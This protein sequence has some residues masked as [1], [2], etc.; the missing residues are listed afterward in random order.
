MTF[1]IDFHTHP[2]HHQHYPDPAHE[3]AL[4]VSD[5]YAVGDMV[6]WGLARKLDGIAITDHNQF[7]SGLYGA[8]WAKENNLSIRVIPGAELSVNVRGG[9]EVHILALGVERAFTHDC[10]DSLE[11]VVKQI[12]DANGLAIMA[13]PHYYH[14]DV[15]SAVLRFVDGAEERNGVAAHCGYRWSV[16]PDYRGLL[17]CGSDYHLEQKAVK[18]QL[19]TYTLV[20]DDCELVRL[21]KQR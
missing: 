1:K 19:N 13:H 9:C 21:M 4:T 18:A 3:R 2:L 17:T 7:T 15:V 11:N 20:S 12:H 10:D 6:L 5:M 8:E 14:P 16:P